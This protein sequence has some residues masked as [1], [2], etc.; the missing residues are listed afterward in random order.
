MEQPFVSIVIPAY[1]AASTI[2]QTIEACRNQD[3]PSDK[4][5]IIVVDDGSKDN[6]KEAALRFGIKYI[7]QKKTGPASARNSGWRNSKGGAICF[8]DADCIPEPDWVSKLVRHYG[9]SAIGAVAGSYSV[10]G[11]PYLL[12]KFVHY[13]IRDRHLRMPEFINSFGTY[14]VMIKRHVLEAVKGFNAEYYSASG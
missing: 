11:S 7:S 14:N 9:V 6:T 5:E 13:E 10:H 2:G 8:T 3:Y 12:D 1:N 4:I